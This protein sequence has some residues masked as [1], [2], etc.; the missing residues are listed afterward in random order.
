MMRLVL[1][2]IKISHFNL[3]G[4]EWSFQSFRNGMTTPFLRNGMESF[5][6]C[7]NGMSTSFLPEWNNHFIPAGME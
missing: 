7:K 1:T 3:N 2:R 6:S 4:M 5:H